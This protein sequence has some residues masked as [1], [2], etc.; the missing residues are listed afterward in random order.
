MNIRKEVQEYPNKPLEEALIDKLKD[1]KDNG[2]KTFTV[3][4]DKQLS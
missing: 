3:G 4:L 1:D 2:E